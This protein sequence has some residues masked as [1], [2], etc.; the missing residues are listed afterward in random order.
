MT[1]RHEDT[2][3]A[4]D[5]LATRSDDELYDIL[6][7]IDRQLAPERYTAVRDEFA[8]RHGASIK[9]QSLDD[10]FDQARLNRPFAERSTFKKKIL[11]GFAIWSLAMLVVRAV[12][13]LRSV[14]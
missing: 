12:L 3:S 7:H 1:I 10:Y 6:T 5:D 9:G 4:S 2:A 13:Y 8:R 11:I 14:R